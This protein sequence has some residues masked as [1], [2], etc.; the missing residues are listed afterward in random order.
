MANIKL[1]SSF[2]NEKERERFF[3]ERA[4]IQN[5]FNKKV[6]ELNTE[7]EQI[8]EDHKEKI[9]YSII[10]PGYP[11]CTCVRLSADALN[12]FYYKIRKLYSEEIGILLHEI[13]IVRREYLY[14]LKFQNSFVIKFI[15]VQSQ[16]NNSSAEF[17][18]NKLDFDDVKFKLV[19]NSMGACLDPKFID[20][21]N[22][23]LVKNL[24]LEV[25]DTISK[26][27]KAE[28]INEE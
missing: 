17:S 11:D 15:F 16:F 19:D 7:V 6:E 21:E 23:F 25:I 22:Y 8:L 14:D 2:N 24:L 13:Q 10:F 1:I 27:E 12:N 18:L 3:I 9:L 5:A 26:I 4:E 28:E 20:P